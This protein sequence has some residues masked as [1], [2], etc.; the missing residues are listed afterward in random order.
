MLH[1][2]QL[3]ETRVEAFRHLADRTD[4]EE[5][6]GFVLAMIQADIFGVSIANVLRAQAKELRV[7]RRQR[8]ERKAMQTPVKLIFP[9]IF[10]L[11]P[12]LMITVVGPAII[13]LSQT[14]F[15]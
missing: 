11:L 7:K 5:L 13:R 3:G 1:E 9:L 14:F 10:C 2:V 6:R 12:A 4:V 8:A 15:H